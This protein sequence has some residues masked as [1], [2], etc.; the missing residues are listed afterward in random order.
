MNVTELLQ[1]LREQHEQATA[2]AH[3][4]RGR[5]QEL[6]A[7]LDEAEGRLA[8]LAVTR[9][10]LESLVPA[11]DASPAGPDQPTADTYQQI[12]AVFN[13]HPGQPFRAR[14]LHELLGLPTD[15]ATVNVT[16]SRLGQLARQ[17]IL[18]QPRRGQYEKRT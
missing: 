9:K 8:E 16:R 12:L 17:G 11:Q 3:G 18:T 14:E 13:N 6:T 10:N 4:L 15:E 7:A 1:L 5:I 2:H